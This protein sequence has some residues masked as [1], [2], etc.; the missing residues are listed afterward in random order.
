[1]K[2]T[3]KLLFTALL[4]ASMF[5]F[6][7]CGNTTGN[8]SDEAGNANNTTQ[9]PNDNAGNNDNK[10]TGNGTT[11]GNQTNNGDRNDNVGNAVGDAVDDAGNAVGVSLMMQAMR[12]RMLHMAQVMS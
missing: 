9:T 10:T 5:T 7:A 2:K 1:M 12:S 8:N 6:A 4:V 3:R 11:S